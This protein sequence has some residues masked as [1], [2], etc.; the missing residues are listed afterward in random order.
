MPAILAPGIILTFFRHKIKT[1]RTMQLFCASQMHTAP[2]YTVTAD[3]G[4]YSVDHLNFKSE[5]EMFVWIRAKLQGF[6]FHQTK[7]CSTLA[8]LMLL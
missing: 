4:I 7:I 8:A 6:C 1:V 5:G 2:S 3:H